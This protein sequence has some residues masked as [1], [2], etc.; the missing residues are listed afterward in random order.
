MARRPRI[1]ETSLAK[2]GV[3]RLSEL[4]VS[5]ARTNKAL[6]QALQLALETEEGVD[7]LAASIRQRIATI[8]RSE[9]RLSTNKGREMIAELKR[10]H[11]SIVNDVSA[12]DPAEG[13]ELLWLFI[14]LHQNLI[15]RTRDRA[16]RLGD[17]FSGVVQELPE[18]A[19]RAKPDAEH[20][21]EGVFNR[22]IDDVYGIYE[23]LISVMA[24]PLTGDGFKALEA[25]LL[26]ARDVASRNKAQNRRRLGIIEHGLRDVADGVGDVD[27]FIATFSIEQTRHP[28]LAAEMAIR[29]VGVDRAEE[30]LK[31]L[32]HAAPDADDDRGARFKWTD[33]RL[34]ALGK[35]GRTDECKVLSWEIFETHL[36]DDHL[37]SHLKLLPDFD[38]IE[39]EERALDW[40]VEQ[41]NF[42]MALSFLIR[43][44]ALPRAAALIE[45]RGAE[46]D[47][48]LYEFFS[49]AAET[50]E[51][52][53]PLAAAI[54]RRAVIRFALEK[55]RGHRFKQMA[56]QVMVLQSLD[57]AI[58]EYGEHERHKDFMEQL[59]LD[60]PHKTK[61]WTLLE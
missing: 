26:E 58:E 24:E 22:F 20:L 17:F 21:A 34:A 45:R 46:I 37:R 57:A 40:V 47:G 5:E 59:W 55:G 48:D 36:S 15:R 14:D 44:P 18:L 49:R 54:L 53:H 4:L 9:S 13:L 25:H 2:L 60:H 50:L 33:A 35:L 11:A 10:L 29:L 6:K 30:A 7:S 38:D 61:F 31:L 43:W 23:D 28:A 3:E 16:G 56:Q 51:G 42:L 12:A 52:R 27:A 39:A 1:T 19:M 32:E 8:D 41:P